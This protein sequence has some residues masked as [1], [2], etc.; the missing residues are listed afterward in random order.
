MAKRKNSKKKGKRGKKKSGGLTVLIVAVL[1]ILAVVAVSKVKR[2]P[3]VKAI[4]AQVVGEFGTA[5]DKLGQFNSPRGIAIAPNGTVY[6]ADINNSR[7]NM[8]TPDGK[9]LG[10]FGKKGNKKGEFNEPSGVAA[11]QNGNVYVADAWNGRFQKFDSK[12]NYLLEVGGTK[13]NFYSPRNIGV[14]KYG[15]VYVSDTGTSRIHRFDT[16]GNR[17]GNPVGGK[18]KALDKFGEVFCAAFDSKGRVY[19][20]DK[21]N[22]R[23]VVL[24]SDLRPISQI[25]VKSWQE[26]DPMWPMLAVDSKDLL[27]AVS[28]GT[29]DITVFD[30]KDKKWKALGVIKTDAKERPI[31][32]DPLGIAV[33]KDDV[34]LVSEITRNKIVKV[35][36]LFDQQ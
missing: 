25:K 4:K 15:I 14:S 3:V 24:S 6:V 27:Y 13:G 19:I 5:G 36:P 1:I 8:F 9:P 28:S 11:D 20:S 29:K 26:S 17:L 16:E 31:F 7:V 18:G 30:T 12:G 32:S 21:D 23:I 2:G 34:L 35:K 10:S 33:D 22:R